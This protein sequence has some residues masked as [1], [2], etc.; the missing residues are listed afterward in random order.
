[1]AIKSKNKRVELCLMVAAA[2]VVL[3][4][5]PVAADTCPVIVDGDVIPFGIPPESPNVDRSWDHS[6]IGLVVERGDGFVDIGLPAA[7]RGS[8][9][10]DKWG[11]HG[12]ITFS[13]AAIATVK[14]WDNSGALVVMN[15]HV[16]YGLE[17]G[18][19]DDAYIGTEE[20]PVTSRD[21]V[22]WGTNSVEFWLATG[23]ARDC[24]RIELTSSGPAFMKIEYIDG[25]HVDNEKYGL[26]PTSPA[27]TRN[28]DEWIPL[29]YLCNVD[30]EIKP[31]TLNLKS[32][33]GFTAFIDLPELIDEE[34]INISTVVCAGA[35][36][37]DAMMA[38]DGRLIVK[39]DR[40]DLV[41]VL[42]KDAVELTVDGELTNGTP[43]TGSD[44]IRVIDKGG[45]K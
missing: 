10:F 40:E 15:G 44:T 12:S 41:G 34:D 37:V 38:D 26:G 16:R 21:E 43:F 8:G 24:F 11:I 36:A 13:G 28:Y 35:P 3:V 18:D 2:C 45:K 19:D 6:Q 33:G 14:D 17:G 20:S 22:D 25:Y 9:S 31:E 4:A 30:I 27:D 29:N 7:R 23:G 42:P 1:M 5:S 32:K 39:F